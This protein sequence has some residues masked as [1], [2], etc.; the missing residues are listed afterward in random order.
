MPSIWQTEELLQRAVQ[1]PSEHMSPA[2][3]TWLASQA[4][5]YAPG[6]SS[7]PPAHD[8]SAAA[9]ASKSPALSID[10]IPPLRPPQHSLKHA[11]GTKAPAAFRG[12]APFGG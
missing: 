10:R 4:S 3:Q 5:L 12:L 8:S 2:T 6:G 7:L 11:A 9:A 1:T